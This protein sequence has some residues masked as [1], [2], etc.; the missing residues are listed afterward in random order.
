M[1]TE[2]QPSEEIV[3]L[4][5][6]VTEGSLDDSQSARLNEMI[7]A[8]QRVRDYYVD[9]MSVHAM[10]DWRHGGVHVLDIP[11]RETGA[12]ILAVPAK[13]SWWGTAAVVASVLIA[14]G[15]AIFTMTR[16]NDPVAL[17][18]GSEQTEWGDEHGPRGGTGGFRAGRQ[19]LDSG[20]AQIQLGSGVIIAMQGPVEF[21]L[22]PGNSF[23]LVK[24]TIR[25]Y[26]PAEA[27]GFTVYT[28]SLDIVDMG[29]EF[30]VIVDDRQNV[31]V[32]VFDGRVRIKNEID[33]TAGEARFVDVEE[34]VAREIDV[35]E[36]NFP[37]IE[38]Q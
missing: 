11:L 26:A 21:V 17:L 10:L 31:E 9:Y 34:H 7:A 38:T 2:Y 24:G 16:P 25:A 28:P 27:I 18:I 35:K 37:S 13:T 19:Q 22:Q 14:V 33:L 36:C 32:H 4:L 3:E 29:T 23:R 30:G 8:D 20:V 12:T 1:N 15:L 6:A 5:T